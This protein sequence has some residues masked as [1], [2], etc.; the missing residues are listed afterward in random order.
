MPTVLSKYSNLTQRVITGVAGII[1]V[2]GAVL[3]ND[4]TYFFLFLLISTLSLLEFFRL[5]GHDGMSPLK[6]YGTLVGVIIYSLSFLVEKEWVPTEYYVILFPLATG[7]FFVGLFKS[8]LKKPFTSIAYTFCGIIYIS[9]PFALLNTIAFEGGTYH[10]QIIMGILI[11]TWM[12][13]IGAYFCGRSFGKR[14]LF[15][16]ISPKK[17]WEG[18][19]GG[20]LLTL[21]LSVLLSFIFHD[22]TLLQWLVIAGII[23]TVGPYGDLVESLLKR[24]MAIKDSGAFLPGHGG[25]LDRFDSLLLSSHF[26]AVFLIIF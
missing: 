18:S 15:E 19:I 26:I 17:S 20:A 4:W 25:F 2:I 1:L 24:G 5:T 11:L 10:A 21:G 13:D 7:I 6:Q 23:G 8:K 14:K 9:V 16:R 22:L 3:W 12:N